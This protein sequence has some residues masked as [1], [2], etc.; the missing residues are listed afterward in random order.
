[1]AFRMKNSPLI[2]VVMPAYNAEEFI[3]ESIASV[4]A[5]NYE[6]WELLII[7][8]HSTDNTAFISADWQKRDSRIK[9]I[10]LTTNQGAGFV[11]NIGIKAA[12]GEYISFLDA[13]DIWKPH[14]LQAQVEFMIKNKI[15]VSYS[16]YEL[17]DEQGN[18][19]NRMVLAIKEL[20]F[21]KML[22]ANY[23][24]NLTG[25]YHVKNLGKMYCPPIRKRQDWAMW[26]NAVRKAGI[27]KGIQ[28]PLAI[29]R[30]RKH[31]ISGNKWELLSYNYQVYREVLGFSAVKSGIFFIKFLWEQFLVKPKQTLVLKK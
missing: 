12:E 13:D 18:S 31:S 30:I 9:L 28:E 20:S 22:K 16:S 7:D 26:L 17:M 10:R 21:T 8:D 6:N 2:S 24:G 4:Q 5:Q 11:R 23:I 1:M 25:M 29:Y 14:K 19:L 3:A 15:S 27:A